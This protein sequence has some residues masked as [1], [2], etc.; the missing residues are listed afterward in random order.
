MRKF[1]RNL[2][3]SVANEATREYPRPRFAMQIAKAEI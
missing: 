2:L 1:D 3:E